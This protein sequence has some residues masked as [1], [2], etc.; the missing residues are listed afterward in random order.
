MQPI[1]TD[2]VAW[3]VGRS[4]C[5][6][7]ESYKNGSTDRDAV[8]VEDSGG[9]KEPWDG[10]FRQML[11]HRRRI[12]ATFTG[13]SRYFLPFYLSVCYAREPWLK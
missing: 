3:F 13:N 4:V 2:R 7:S 9:L 8:W 12:K 10:R 11:K 5:H 6:S 1:I